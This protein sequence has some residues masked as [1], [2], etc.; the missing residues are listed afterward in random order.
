MHQ[1]IIVW[2][3]QTDPDV[4]TGTSAGLEKLLYDATK[5]KAGAIWTESREW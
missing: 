2:A 1:L 5:E 4:D 3:L